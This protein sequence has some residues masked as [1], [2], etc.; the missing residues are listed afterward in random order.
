FAKP[1]SRTVSR[2]RLRFA[3]PAGSMTNS[4]VLFGAS[5][6]S[7]RPPPS[8]RNRIRFGGSWA[9]MASWK[10]PCTGS[11]TWVTAPWRVILCSRYSPSL[12]NQPGSR[13]TANTSSALAWIRTLRTIS[14]G[15]GLPGGRTGSSAMTVLL[16]VGLR[17]P[18]RRLRRSWQTSRCRASARRRGGRAAGAEMRRPRRQYRRKTCGAGPR[19]AEGLELV[20]PFPAQRLGRRGAVL[21]L[22]GGLPADHLVLVVGGDE[23][24]GA[25]VAAHGVAV[26]VH[27]ELLADLVDPLG[28]VGAAHGAGAVELMVPSRQREQVEHLLGGDVDGAGDGQ[29]GLVGVHGSHPAAAFWGCHPGLDRPV[30]RAGHAGGTGRSE[31]SADGAD[32]PDGPS[33]RVGHRLLDGQGRALQHLL[34][35]VADHVQLPGGD[36]GVGA[37]PGLDLPVR[38]AVG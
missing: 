31:G 29:V 35:T 15:I 4:T 7:P 16:G 22:R 1:R 17:R 9:S 23:V 19:G 3:V 27:H 10:E 20:E 28:V 38:R 26:H 33:Q 25:V 12:M 18:R 8:Q 24:V 13:M 36:R 30:A 32:P 21:P 2:T 6:I 5:E 37:D 34:H 11:T 14:S